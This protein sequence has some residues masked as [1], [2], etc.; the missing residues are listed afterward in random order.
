MSVTS[1]A[2][3]RPLL[4]ARDVLPQRVAWPRKLLL[5]GHVLSLDAVAVA[6]VWQHAVGQALHAAP[7]AFER[8]ALALAVW[9]VYLLDRQLDA[10]KLDRSATLRHRLHRRNAA[11][12]TALSLC[13]V[14]ALAFLATRLPPPLLLRGG[15]VAALTATYL[16]VVQ[17]FPR[18]LAGGAKELC[19]GVVF[20]AGCVL[21]IP[22][23]TPH[24][25]VVTATMAAL[26]SLNCLL[27]SAWERR[28]EQGVRTTGDAS[29]G[30]G[31]SPLRREPCETTSPTTGETPVPRESLLRAATLVLAATATL[32]ALLLGY[33]F[34]PAILNCASLAAL[35]LGALDLLARRKYSTTIRIAADLV[36]LTPLLLPW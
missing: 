13:G 15:T 18:L 31:V 19:V 14:A 2:F 17:R 5:A 7:S 36:L 20:A 25:F 29:C 22:W 35:L 11:G 9:C 30:M 1:N 8:A 23:R 21:Q 4:V 27:I 26:F 10:R 6:V 12:I 3:A 24:L 16:F 28:Y 34:R 32:T 33:P